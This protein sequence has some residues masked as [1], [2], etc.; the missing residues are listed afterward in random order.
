MIH[1]VCEPLTLH[2]NKQSIRE[3]NG[4]VALPSVVAFLNTRDPILSQLWLSTI[5][6]LQSEILKGIWVKVS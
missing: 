4:S 3:A 5:Q 1:K 6:D 2:G